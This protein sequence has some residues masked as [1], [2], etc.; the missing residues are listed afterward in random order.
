M[1]VIKRR[2]VFLILLLTI[3]SACR[4]QTAPP[5]PAAPTKTVTSTAA[6][7]PSP[8]PTSEPPSVLTVC[9]AQLPESLV[10]YLGDPIPAKRH[11]LK[12]LYE[13]PYQTVGGERIPIILDRVPSLVNGDQRMEPVTVQRGQTVVDAEGDLAVFQPGLAVRPSGCQE[14]A[15]AVIWDGA[16]PFLMDRMVVDFKL[17]E[18]LAWSDGQPVSAGDSVFSFQLADDP[19]APGLHWAE[20]RTDAYQALDDATVRWVGVPGFSTLDL[21]SFFWKPL[22]AHLFAAETDWVAMANSETLADSPLS[23]GP[24]QVDTR[25]PERIRLIPNP[26]YFKMEEGLPLLDE[27]VF[28]QVGGGREGALQALRAGTCDLLDASFGW[29]NDPGLLSQ[30]EME[31]LGK[32]QAQTGEAW[33][34]LA[35]G[36]VPAAYDDSYNPA[37]GDRPDYFGDPAVRTGL[38]ACLDREAMRA[39]ALGDWGQVWPSFLPPESSQLPAGEGLIFNPEQGAAALEASGWVDFDD[40]PATPRV[41]VNLPNVPAGS[42]LRLE[43]LIDTTPFQQDMAHIIQEN[44]AVCGVAVEIQSLTPEDLYAPGPDG[45]LFGRRFDLALIAWRPEPGLDC[46]LYFDQAL[47]AAAQHWVGTNIP[48]FRQQE[49]DQTCAAAELAYG[50]K[51]LEAVAQAELVFVNNL[52]AV[53]LFSPPQATIFSSSLCLE[54]ILTTGKE[55]FNEIGRVSGD[56]NCP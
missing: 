47:P 5:T 34:Q 28:E 39:R 44:L 26:H 9:T 32:V 3:L 10:P 46:R 24:F 23:Y 1:L 27:L 41:A 56:K 43:L 52:P 11:L 7:V 35:F 45:P 48:G 53:P 4:S 6:P 15:C 55:F 42:E 30:I 29:E 33:W 49:Y 17:A 18:K 51:R 20:A 2:L 14:A 19:Q 22:P 37:L 38:A 12:I 13:E 40:D 31:G 54:E 21:K 8:T 36:I 50:V 25:E 16:A